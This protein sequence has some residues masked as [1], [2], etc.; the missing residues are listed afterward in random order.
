MVSGDC[1]TKPP[2]TKPPITGYPHDGG[3]CH[4]VTWTCPNASEARP[5]RLRY[6]WVERQ[7]V[8]DIRESAS[9]K[10]SDYEC[11]GR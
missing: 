9:A 11:K 3:G 5:M 2:I 4:S 10:L 6:E 8:D 7:E 1:S